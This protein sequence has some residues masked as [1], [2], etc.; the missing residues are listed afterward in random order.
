MTLTYENF[1]W[2]GREDTWT[3]PCAIV[4]SLILATELYKITK[5]DRYKTLAR[6]IWFNGLQFC[7]RDNGG[8][9]PNTCVT[10]SQT[11][12]KVSMYEAYFCCT[13]RYAEGLLE[14]SNNESLFGWNEN[15]PTEMDEIGRRFIDDK[16]LV[17]YNGE[18]TPIFPCHAF[19]KDE[20]KEISVK[21]I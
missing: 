19:T 12:L 2:F 3:E 13:M 10:T 6:R 4:D 11:I 16:L 7:H 15:A 5:N 14:Y 8:A 18:W 20:A 9:G 1:N 17:E 21:V